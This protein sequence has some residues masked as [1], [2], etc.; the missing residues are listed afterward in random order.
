MN[1]ASAAFYASLLLALLAAIWSVR[2]RDPSARASATLLLGLCVA[3][4]LVLL[5]AIPV[6][7]V[8]VVAAATQAATLRSSESARAQGH[9]QPLRVSRAPGD[10]LSLRAPA[11]LQR[12]AAPAES[13]A[14]VGDAPRKP[15]MQR[16]ASNFHRDA[17]WRRRGVVA[18]YAVT[19][20]VLTFVFLGTLARQYLSLGAVLDDGGKQ[21]ERFG[22]AVGFSDA[23]LGPAH[24]AVLM[25]LA[26]M[27]L[28]VL[29]N[30]AIERARRKA[31]DA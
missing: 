7:L 6:A 14:R 10:S 15:A 30:A 24:V 11:H 5:M 3:V 13:A 18:T 21:V 20:A 19:G 8:V 9:V 12:D 2:S 16:L 22:T 25:L 28:A 27:S 29:G 26:T 31:G 4:Q 17:Q 1:A 23:V